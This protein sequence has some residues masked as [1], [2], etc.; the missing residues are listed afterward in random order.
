MRSD[1]MIQRVVAL[2]SRGWVTLAVAGAMLA[3]TFT[4]TPS[5]AQSGNGAG[6]A[7]AGGNGASGGAVTVTRGASGGAQDASQGP[8]NGAQGSP[9][10]SRGVGAAV[11]VSPGSGWL[12]FSW[13]N[14]NTQA[15]G[16]SPA[17]PQG[18]VCDPSSGATFV[19]AAP[20]TFSGAATLKVVDGFA[21]GDRY[22][23]FDNGVSI[24][25]TS[26][27]TSGTT[28][29]ADPAA[30]D[31]NASASKGTFNLGA[32]SHSITIRATQV[33]PGISPPRGSAYFR[34][35]GG[36]GTGSCTVTQNVSYL[37]GTLHADWTVTTGNQAVTWI[38]YA[39]VGGAVIPLAAQ[40]FGANQTSSPAQINAAGF[41]SIGGIGFLTVLIA[42]P[43]G[44]ICGDFD[45]V[46]T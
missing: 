11:A 32:G 1:D 7:G 18:L 34:V 37:G 27:P 8:N 25:Q 12:Q 45:I 3:S 44:V 46:V 36:G 16:C 14:L 23:V 19:G 24:G 13:F 35:D 10:T 20:W 4:A 30:C 41:P 9:S 22:E 31:A 33:A 43:G 39:V 5:M 28:C 38:A 29:G 2:R 26:I 21:T 40:N 17:D 6:A 15:L 42:N